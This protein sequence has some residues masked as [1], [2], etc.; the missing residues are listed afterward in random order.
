MTQT[1]EL[2]NQLVSNFPRRK[3]EL[4]RLLEQMGIE[5]PQQFTVEK[6]QPLSAM[7]TFKQKTKR[8]LSPMLKERFVCFGTFIQG[9]EIWLSGQ[10]LEQA[11][12]SDE[13]LS[14]HE[15]LRN[16]WENSL[17]ARFEDD[18]LSIF[19]YTP[20]VF[21]EAVY[22]AWTEAIEPIVAEYKSTSVNQFDCLDDFLRWKIERP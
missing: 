9:P 20:G 19:G 7:P 5:E 2:L 15:A 6:P 21:D 12:A 14:L 16:N 4:E 10:E 13:I 18:E 17:P 1:K 11:I 22:L 8:S 3:A